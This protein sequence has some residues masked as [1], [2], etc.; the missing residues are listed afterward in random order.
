VGKVVC[1]VVAALTLLVY[2]GAIIVGLRASDLSVDFFHAKYAGRAAWSRPRTA[3]LPDGTLGQS[4]RLGEMIFNETP[5]YAA[6]HTG[7]KVTCANCHEAG[8]TQP[9]ASPMVGL[10]ALFPM[11]NQRAGRKISL[12]DRIQECFV[13]SENGKPLDYNGVKMKALVDYMQWLS[14]P[15]PAAAKF[16]GRGLLMQPDLTP[17][18]VHGAAVYAAQCAGCHGWNG[19][20]ARP[21]APPLWG[22]NSFNDGAGM[23]G[24]KKMAAFVRVNM[25]YNRKG[26][27]SAQDSF[28]VAAYVHVQPRPKFNE[29]YK[30]Y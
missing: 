12:E 14:T 28:D 30:K 19:E 5:L 25:P 22:E 1:G 23:H 2:A 24:V 9:W 6:E 16:V 17:D 7:A 8:G 18:P 27:L 21:V 20:G 3:A 26:E 4:V 10:P 29:A 11:Y 15:Q 13:R